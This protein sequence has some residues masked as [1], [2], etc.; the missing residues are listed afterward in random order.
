MKKAET[1]CWSLK[2]IFFQHVIEGAEGKML[3]VSVPVV[4]W[5]K[6]WHVIELFLLTFQPG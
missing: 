1:K 4:T 3:N 6:E 2:T 5:D